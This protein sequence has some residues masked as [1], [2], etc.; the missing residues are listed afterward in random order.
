MK[1]RRDKQDKGP[2]GISI[3]VGTK[4]QLIKIAPL[5]IELEKRQIE[6]NFIFTGQ[7][8]ET[9]GGLI[10]AFG[11][12]KPDY[13]LYEGRDITKVLQLVSWALRCLVHTLRNKHKIFGHYHG[14]VLV[15]GDAF[16][17]LVGALIAKV[18][19]RKV[20]YVE[21]GLR[22]FHLFSPFPEEIT[23]RIASRMAD[24]HFCPGDFAYDNS[25]SYKGVKV[26]TAAN[27]LLDSL[28]LALK[29]KG[30]VRPYV[31]EE[32]YCLA[33][34]HRFEN[35][36]NRKRLH[37]IVDILEEISQEIKVLFILHKPTEE[38]LGEFGFKQRLT[39]A[40]NIELRPRYDYFKFIKLV[41]KSE[42]VIT[43]GGSN[44]EECHYL[45]KPCLLMRGATERKEGLDKNVI[46]SRYDRIIIRDFVAYYQ[47]YR[48]PPLDFDASP[49]KKIVDYLEKVVH[50]KRG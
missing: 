21:A 31:P 12:K 7:H 37:F 36:F 46:I 10:E 49:S 11:L 23:R 39:T 29:N 4:A 2:N 42:F 48:I 30:D 22:S 26:N 19:R 38:K 25:K 34:I 18:C 27:T 15:H 40:P 24:Y 43:D 50:E 8:K 35:I 47:S 9:I 32:E 17:V 1:S 16:S 3:I 45:G 5:M 6:Y 14:P 44:Q 20:G 41:M 13:I 28:K 33:S